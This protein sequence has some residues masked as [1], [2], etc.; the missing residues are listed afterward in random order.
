MLVLLDGDLAAMAG[1]RF[2]SGL[3]QCR[4]LR[5]CRFLVGFG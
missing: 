2:D 5:V 4:L 1:L 3:L